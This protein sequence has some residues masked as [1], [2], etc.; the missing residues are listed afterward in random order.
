MSSIAK[1]Y[2]LNQSNIKFKEN[3][4]MKTISRKTNWNG[5]VF[6]AVAVFLNANTA[7]AK[8]LP[9]EAYTKPDAV[10]AGSFQFSPTGEYFAIV[11]PR[12]DRSSLIIIDRATSRPTANV[13]PDKGQ[14][15]NG[16]HWVSPSR[17]V[18]S[19]AEK[20]GGFSTPSSTGE[21]WGMDADGGN[22]QYLFGYR[23]AKDAGT[24][25]KRAVAMNASAVVL[26]PL[27]DNK[28]TILIA[29]FSWATTGESS[30]GELA[31]LNVENGALLKTGGRIPLRYFNNVLVDQENKVRVVSGVTKERYSQLLYRNTKTSEWVTINDEKKT[32][33]VIEPL[34]Y[35]KDGVD[36]FARVSESGRP[37]YLIQMN[38]ETLDEKKV[39]S[40][41]NAS[42]GEIFLTAD[43]KNAY[44]I[45]SFDGRGGY[46]FLDKT[47][48]E[49]ILVKTL[50]AQFP[51]ELVI[52]NSFSLDGRFAS[53]FVTS[54][55]N[56][57]EYYIYDR[58]AKKLSSVLA[59]RPDIRPDDAA[60][61]EPVEFK[62]RDG[63][64]IR[65]WLTRPNAQM[66]KMPLVVMP[67]GGPYGI[68]DRWEFNTEAQLLAN[69][70]YA[71]LQIN[72]R[73]SGGYGSDFLNAGM[74][75][76]G[77]KMQQDLTDGTRWLI[78]Q[79]QIDEKRICI[80]GISYGGYA[81]LMGVAT[82]PG[83]F[84]C[85]IGY[86]GVYELAAMSGQGDIDNT[87]YGRQ[88][89]ADIFENNPEWLHARSP[90]RLAE[91]IK[92]PVLL[93]HGGK[94]QRVPAAHAKAMQKALIA[95]GNPPQWIYE[96]SEG[97]GF[98]DPQKR[99]NAYQNIIDFLE[100]NIGSQAKQ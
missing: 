40:P 4:H 78:S 6:L 23:G 97:H 14:Y 7:T 35:T 100:K 90:A 29:I 69:R 88:Y 98:F 24:N 86:A 68:V 83:L 30:F 31:R 32:E 93:I 94:D 1:N 99:L 49:S 89:L 60:S 18:V 56:A 70:G 27:A 84:K 77:G 15:I 57:G 71:V 87:A 92:A 10:E 42:I 58:D 36:F 55:L 5:I 80:Y 13:T 47:L 34:A 76:W 85:A 38:P 2:A 75:E 9:I 21:L 72:Y 62:A 43:R 53:V 22:K 50:M 20:D 26:E 63:L 19:M 39:Y 81:A 44:A 95:A 12:E 91:R 59:V 28:R 73:G 11:V 82:E 16:Y 17:V 41:V 46:A 25:I 66:P 67:H 65:G 54:D 74:R 45:Q 51:G 52:A 79:N 64:T 3:H 33:R 8:L 48:P 61:V 96:E 37:D